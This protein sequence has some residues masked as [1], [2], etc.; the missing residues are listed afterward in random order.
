MS[1]EELSTLCTYIHRI[2]DRTLADKED[3]KCI[4]VWHDFEITSQ[5]SGAPFGYR[6]IQT[7][8]EGILGI[9]HEM[10]VVLDDGSSYACIPEDTISYIA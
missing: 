2:H 6:N 9:K 4:Q 5:K 10:P 7:I 8:H 1:I 3:G